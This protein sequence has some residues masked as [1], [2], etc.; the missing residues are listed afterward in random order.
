[1]SCRFA[2]VAFIAVMV[3]LQASI[4]IAQPSCSGSCA[5]TFFSTGSSTLCQQQLVTITGKNSAA[6]TTSLHGGDIYVFGDDFECASVHRGLTTAG[7]TATVRLFFMGIRQ[8]FIG[9][10]KFGL[11]ST[12]NTGD[13]G[14]AL[15]SSS[16]GCPLSTNNVTT[17]SLVTSSV[18]MYPITGAG[19]FPSATTPLNDA[20]VISRIATGS[21]VFISHRGIRHLFLSTMVSNV[22][23]MASNVS[24]NGYSVHL[25]LADAHQVIRL[26]ALERIQD[27]RR[28]VESSH[29]KC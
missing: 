18:T 19:L 10:T 13:F 11:S 25:S 28:Y 8:E 23:T 7:V 27:G 16:D 1:M 9:M 4:V 29:T 22:Y 2:P 17:V 15:M 3:V 5:S 26:S 12:Y 6:C 24:Q 14:V 20:L 21:T